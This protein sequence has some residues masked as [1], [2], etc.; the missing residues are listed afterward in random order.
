[1]LLEDD[2]AVT[3]VAD[4]FDMSLPAISKHLNIL[5]NADNKEI[6]VSGV[7]IEDDTELPFD[8][9]QSS[10][11][12]YYIFESVT[13]D[14]E[15]IDDE[16]WVVAFRG[17]VCVG[18]KQWNTSACFSGVCDIAVMGDDNTVYTENYMLE[19]EIPEFKIYDCI[20]EGE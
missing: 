7:G 4:P 6:N 2:M 14:Q 19:G 15:L 9:N 20:V 3:D 13:I 17:D 18:A 5:S 8:F 1:M 11:V 16:D 12:A 10:E